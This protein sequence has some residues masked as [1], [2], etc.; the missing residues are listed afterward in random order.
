[1]DVRSKGDGQINSPLITQCKKHNKRNGSQ[2]QSPTDED[3]G[4]TSCRR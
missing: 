2:E 1:M 3:E 4:R